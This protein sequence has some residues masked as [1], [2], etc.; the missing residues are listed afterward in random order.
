MM[1]PTLRKL[2]LTAHVASS[3]GWLGSV[4]GFL[5]LSIA[6][7]TSHS[8]QVVTSA[9]LAMNL[10]GEFLIVPLSLAALLTGVLQSLGT[11]WGLMRYYWVL[12]KFALT[13]GASILLLLHQFTAVAW[14]ANLVAA[15]AIGSLPVVGRLGPKLVGDSGLAVLVLL[16]ATTLSVYK[17]WGRTR[18][19]QRILQGTELSTDD[20]STAEGL[21]VGLRRF[22]VAVLCV[23]LAG[24][25]LSHLAGG[26]FAHHGGHLHH[27]H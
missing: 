20:S 15:T 7:L 16:A 3:V 2:N 23:L 5:V 22:L 11:P 25:L 8:A 12:V 26:G 6:G 21:P 10:I 27:G 24:I 1:T 14:A 17:P 4:T 19:G 13:I 18:Y 9:Y